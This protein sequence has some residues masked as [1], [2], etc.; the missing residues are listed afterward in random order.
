MKDGEYNG[1]VPFSSLVTT[2][3]VL[4]SNKAIKPFTDKL[5]WPL[6]GFNINNF[7]AVK[8]LKLIIDLGSS[9]FAIEHN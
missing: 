3:S 8:V 7:I 1:L 2:V 9:Y 6:H 4:R 5:P